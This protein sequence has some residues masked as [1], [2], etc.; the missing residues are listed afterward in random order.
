M[1]IIT[2]NNRLEWRT[3]GRCVLAL[4]RGPSKDPHTLVHGS[5]AATQSLRAG[6]ERLALLHLQRQLTDVVDTF[7]QAQGRNGICHQ[8]QALRVRP[9]GYPEGSRMRV[10]AVGNDAEVHG[11]AAGHS[12]R[13]EETHQAGIAVVERQHGVEEVRDQGGALLDGTFSVAQRGHGVAQGDGDAALHQLADHLRVA[14]L[15]RR[16]GDDLDAFQRAVSALQGAQ[17][18][19]EKVLMGAGVEGCPGATHLVYGLYAVLGM[20]SLLLGIDERALGMDAQD[21]GALGHRRGNAWQDGVVA[22]AGR[23]HQC[24]AEG[25]DAALHQSARH[26][27][28]ALLDGVGVV[29][30]VHSI[31]AWGRAFNIY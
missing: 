1:K 3:D 9:I 30:E 22:V 28:H 8:D 12:I 6:D 4:T 23:G 7:L 10:D 31:A 18:L 16:Q 19:E 5:D 21:A 11:P 25:G 14:D 17:S 2:N 13:G 20:G 26:L 27:G 24:G 15:L 29:G